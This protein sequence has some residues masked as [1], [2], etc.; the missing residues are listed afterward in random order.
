MFA[1][2]FIKYINVLLPLSSGFKTFWA[3]IIQ[4][5]FLVGIGDLGFVNLNLGFF[6]IL[7]TKKEAP[8]NKKTLTKQGALEWVR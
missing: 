6:N 5:H 2:F 3:R 4:L 7:S 1:S 8:R